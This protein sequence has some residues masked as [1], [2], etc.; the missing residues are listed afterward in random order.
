[1]IPETRFILAAAGL[2]FLTSAASMA[3]TWR[4]SMT[5]PP[6][7]TDTTKSAISQAIG[8]ESRFNGTG[9]VVATGRGQGTGALISPEWVLTARHVVAGASSGTFFYNG[10]NSPIASVHVRSDSDVAL[11]RL[12]TP[13]NNANVPVTPIYQKSDEVGKSVWIVGYGRHGQI[14]GNADPLSD[15]FQGRFGATNRISATG[16]LGSTVGRVII[17]QFDT[18]ASALPTEGATAPGDS[19]GPMFME[20]DGRL[21]I[22][23]ETFGAISGVGFTHGRVSEYKDWIRTTTGINFNEAIWDANP[24]AAGVQQ[25]SGTWTTATSTNPWQF[26]GDN[27]PFAND[28]D[29]IFRGNGAAAT[30]TL[31]SPVTATSIVFESAGYLIDSTGNALTLQANATVTTN[32]D[33][34]L[35]APVSGTAFVKEGDAILSLERSNNFTGKLSIDAGL[36]RISDDNALGTAAGNTTIKGLSSRA[37]LELT[38][39]IS[40]NEPVILQ[41]QQLNTHTQL[42]NIS[43][44][45]TLSGTISL[46]TGGN[47]WDVASSS[48]NLN[49]T[50]QI[51]SIVGAADSDR[52]LYL[53]GPG[54][55]SFSA[56][57]SDSDAGSKVN[58]RVESGSWALVGSAKSYTGATTVG[59]GNF[60]VDS[61]LSSPVT[62][63]NGAVFS[64][65][66]STTEAI[67]VEQGAVFSRPL[68]DWNS[69]GQPFSAASLTDASTS[70]WTLRLDASALAN[71]T[72]TPKTVTILSSASTL[73]GI[74]LGKINSELVGFTGKGDWTV[75]KTQN[76]LDLVYTPDP[77]LFW[78][79]TIAFD[80]SDPTPGGDPDSDGLTNL[81]EFALGSSPLDSTS[82]ATPTLNFVPGNNL[83]FRFFRASEGLTYLV[84]SSLDLANW[85][86]VA[87][88]PGSPGHPVVYSA[89]VATPPGKLFYR[90]EVEEN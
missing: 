26:Q 19:G 79:T 28:Y 10:G 39:G 37:G 5:D 45:N 30:V 13:V 32:Q 77:Y 83:E 62:I 51:K 58:L 86:T 59:G 27:F 63:R 20:Q 14:S 66:G 60:R 46:T 54:S 7:N 73:A 74:D 16:N 78:V 48:G 23:G 22:V 55:G 41:M 90:L 17:F 24:S 40:T 72:E 67:T 68:T 53:R 4:P 31:G 69:P 82:A 29:V 89:P 61:A 56:S 15:S 64:G 6:P 43:G 18:N 57:I 70:S 38:G 25:G 34:I 85:T 12:A 84:R 76:T 49:F 1:M 42:H 88:N 80:G 75:S 8:A 52:T 9:I 81:L 87:T 35:R 50:G 71:F 44:T 65:N 2:W 33:A 21:W 11:L 36:V 47:R 3:I